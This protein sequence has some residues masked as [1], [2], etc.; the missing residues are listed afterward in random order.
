MSAKTISPPDTRQRLRDV[1]A[2]ADGRK[3]IDVKV[4]ELREVCDFAD[5][6]IICTGRSSRQ[7]QAIAEGIRRL[8]RD[9]GE[10]PIHIEGSRTGQWI[11]LDY[12]DLVIHVFDPETRS[13]YALER[14]WLDAP[15][16][17]AE[18]RG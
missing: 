5:F 8:M 6:F 12:G 3:A 4:L 7:V 11:L 10:R 9:Q 18:L 14:L 13:Y 15:D 17:T 2:L 1:V 16:V